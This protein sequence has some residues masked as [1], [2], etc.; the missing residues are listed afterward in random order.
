MP[1]KEACLNPNF[2]SE[3]CQTQLLMCVVFDKWFIYIYK[4]KLYYRGGYE[5]Y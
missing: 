4:K 5:I 1:A 3:V 2:N